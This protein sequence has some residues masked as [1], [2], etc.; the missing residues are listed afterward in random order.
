MAVFIVKV[1]LLQVIDMHEHGSKSEK[2][3]WVTSNRRWLCYLTHSDQHPCQRPAIY[4]FI[5]NPTRQLLL[6]PLFKPSIRIVIY[7]VIDPVEEY[8]RCTPDLSWCRSYRS[9]AIV[10][11]RCDTSM[12]PVDAHNEKS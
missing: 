8:S 4:L 1:G 11:C 10:S 12:V 2:E 7:L 9:M 5:C 3:F 6:V